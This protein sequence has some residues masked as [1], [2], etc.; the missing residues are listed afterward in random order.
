MRLIEILEGWKA[1]E[2]VA[3]EGPRGR[4]TCKLFNL[5]QLPQHSPIFTQK[6]TPITLPSLSPN[7]LQHSQLLPYFHK[8]LYRL[9][10]MLLLMRRT[11]L[12]PDTRLTLRHHGEE[13]ADHV[14]SFIN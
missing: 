12:H 8:P 1:G 5:I 4:S 6:P 2:E 7:S 9:I 14:N 3:G 13:E 10:Q 11:Q